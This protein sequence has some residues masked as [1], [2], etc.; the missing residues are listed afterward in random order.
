M[1]DL[2]TIPET[3]DFLRVSVRQVRRYIHD[4]RLRVIRI[5]YRTVLI[6]RRELDAFLKANE[7]RVA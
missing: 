4:G 6:R 5:G 1:S 7:R 2:L 3:A